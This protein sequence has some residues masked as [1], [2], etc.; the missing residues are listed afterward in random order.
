VTGG[1][2]GETAGEEAEELLRV[3]ENEIKGGNKLFEAKGI[4]FMELA[5]ILTAYWLPIFQEVAGKELITEDK[6][7]AVWDWAQ[8][9]LDFPLIQ[10]NVPSKD[11]LTPLF[12]AQIAAVN[13]I[14]PS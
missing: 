4:G 2:E 14:P 5:G 9:I 6:Y 10:Q 8:R 13:V 12:Q 7:P 11:D 1:E 3:L